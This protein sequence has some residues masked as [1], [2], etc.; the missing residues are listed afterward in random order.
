LKI[1]EV[2]Y[3]FDVDGHYKAYPEAILQKDLVIEDKIGNQDIT[4]TRSL[5][6]EVKLV[7]VESQKEYL[8]L[9]TFWFAWAAFHP[10]TDIY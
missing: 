3:G 9:R 6:G 1:K 5:S 4:I 10:D 2:V 7:S 8:P